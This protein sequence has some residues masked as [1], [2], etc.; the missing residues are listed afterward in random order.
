MASI[1]ST[2]HNKFEHMPG[3]RRRKYYLL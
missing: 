2:R 3:I 1:T